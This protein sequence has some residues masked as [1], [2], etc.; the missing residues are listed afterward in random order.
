MDELSKFLFHR[1]CS[2][3][4][5]LLAISCE[6]REFTAVTSQVRTAFATASRVLLIRRELGS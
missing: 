1:Y 2:T 6:V 3:A 5:I 4:P